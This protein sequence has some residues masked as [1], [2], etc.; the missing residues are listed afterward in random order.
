MVKYGVIPNNVYM[1]LYN[2]P[3]TA[4]GAVKDA[5]ETTIE[6][7]ITNELSTGCEA[8]REVDRAALERVE[9]PPPFQVGF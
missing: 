3:D 8:P 7:V 9:K 6:S 4:S 5:C 1:D 2:N